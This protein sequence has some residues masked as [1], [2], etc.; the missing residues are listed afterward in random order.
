MK[1]APN[2]S[3]CFHCSVHCSVVLSHSTQKP[4]ILSNHKPAH[5]TPLLKT[6]PWF[7]TVFH[8]KTVLTA[9]RTCP[10]YSWLRAFARTVLYALLFC[11]HCC[12]HLYLSPLSCSH[13]SSH[14][15]PSSSNQMKDPLLREVFWDLSLCLN[16]CR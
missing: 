6:F 5:V 4:V 12:L 9:P 2:F 8:W 13:S 3:P 7:S 10:A 1:Q 14:P 15:P 11:R 16:S